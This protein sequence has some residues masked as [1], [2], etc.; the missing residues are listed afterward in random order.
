MSLST[1][2]KLL[3]FAWLAAGALYLAV[4]TGGFRR[5]AKELELP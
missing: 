1:N 3:G 5:P 2:A 4:L